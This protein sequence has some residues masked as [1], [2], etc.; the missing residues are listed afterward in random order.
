ML[1]INNRDMETFMILWEPN[2]QLDQGHNY[3]YNSFHLTHL[4]EVM[5]GLSYTEGLEKLLNSATS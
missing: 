5:I 1:A 3:M 4:L 2:S